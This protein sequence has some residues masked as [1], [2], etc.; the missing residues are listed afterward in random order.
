MRL[1]DTH[2]GTQCQTCYRTLIHQIHLRATTVVITERH[3]EPLAL[4][5]NLQGKNGMTEHHIVPAHL[6]RNHISC[7]QT[8]VITR[9]FVLEIPGLHIMDLHMESERRL[10][11][12]I[13]Q[14]QLQIKRQHL[15]RRT[16]FG[17]VEAL[18]LPSYILEYQ[19]HLES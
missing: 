15:L 8:L 11:N 18:Q 1:L 5:H 16:I 12:T 2:A 4:G 13:R 17:R 10:G 9:P 19:A 7:R 14:P 3:I 6:M